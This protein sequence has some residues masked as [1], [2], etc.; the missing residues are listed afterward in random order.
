MTLKQGA[1]VLRQ[2]RQ[3]PAAEQLTWAPG[4]QVDFQGVHS[5]RQG[6]KERNDKFAISTAWRLESL[7]LEEWLTT[8]YADKLHSRVIGELRA[9]PSGPSMSWAP[10]Q[11]S[12]KLGRGPNKKEV[13]DPRPAEAI[14]RVNE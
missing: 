7:L 3:S 14:G 1:S 11:T 12:L 5:H 6:D 8:A 13:V 2:A 9:I 4:E 10:R